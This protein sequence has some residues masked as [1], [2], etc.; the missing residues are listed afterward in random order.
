MRTRIPQ[1]DRVPRSWAIVSG[2]VMVTTILGGH[3]S[4]FAAVMGV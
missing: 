2:L 1:G 3:A 4:L